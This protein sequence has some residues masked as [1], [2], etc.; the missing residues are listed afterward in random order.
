VP[1][2]DTTWFITGTDTE[3]GK[4]VVTACLA[5]AFHGTALAAKTVAS[6]VELPPGED[7]ALLGFAAGHPAQVFQTWA[8]PLSPHRAAALED[9]PL[10][11]P[12]FLAW[13]SALHGAPL[14]VEGVGGWTVP[15]SPELAVPD[16][17]RRLGAPVLLVAAD[18]LG[19]LNHTLLSARAIQADGLRLAGVVLNRGLPGDPSSQY[20]LDDLRTLL[21]VPV[22]VC[23]TVDLS[24]VDAMA[25]VGRV[26]WAD[27]A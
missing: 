22:A 25:A 24:S 8:A 16:V 2:I 7:A 27:L 5:A 13:L 26:L 4:T 20:N 3:V 17:A 1:L 12:A 18:R 23:P 6:G 14:L 9:R 19:V 21:Q 11:V 15:L 10:D